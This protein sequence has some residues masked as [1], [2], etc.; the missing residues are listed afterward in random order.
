MRGVRE[1]A[2][3]RWGILQTP[4]LVAY[5]EDAAQCNVGTSVPRLGPQRV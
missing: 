5:A 2:L 4:Y 1:Q 3:Y